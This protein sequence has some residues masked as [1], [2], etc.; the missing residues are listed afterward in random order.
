MKS[1]VLKL[2]GVLLFCSALS[3][4][5]ESDE[6][7]RQYQIENVSGFDVTITFFD[8]FTDE[9]FEV[10][11][12]NGQVYNGDLLTYTSGNPQLNKSESFFPSEAYKKSDSLEIVFNNEKYITAFITFMT[13]TEATFSEPKERNLFR[14]GSYRKQDNEFFI[15]TI[16]EEDYQAA[17]P[18]NGVCD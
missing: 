2:V 10:T 14:H 11:I 8:T 18:C 15:F 1:S 17:Q 4:V 7:D 6:I 12:N 13:P 3:C 16:S 5:T 9:S